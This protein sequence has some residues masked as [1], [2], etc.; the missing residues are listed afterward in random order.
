MAKKSNKI[1]NIA[2]DPGKHSTKYTYTGGDGKVVRGKFETSISMSNNLISSLGNTKEI[3]YDGNTYVVGEGSIGRTSKSN[4]K[5]DLIHKIC[6]L[7]A[8]S[9]CI[10]NGDTVNVVIGCPIAE[11]RSDEKRKA[12]RDY[13]F[14]KGR[15]EMVI[16]NQEM[17][18][19]TGKRYVMAE[20]TGLTIT[21]PERF[22]DKIVGVIDI[23]GLN[24]NGSLY[25]SGVIVEDSYFTAKLGSNVIA[26]KLR[27]DINNELDLSIDSN[28]MK[29]FMQQGYVTNFEEE[30]REMFT[31]RYKSHIEKI[32]EECDGNGWELKV[33][34]LIFIGGTSLM[35]KD[36]I[37]DLFPKAYIPEDSDYTNVNGFYK[38]INTI[39]KMPKGRLQAQ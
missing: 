8:V 23:G 36:Y 17:Y 37:L 31:K 13:M 24:C 27:K 4:S 2:I 3:T 33:M 11:F 7:V 10:N 28:M 22:K 16:G 19:Y 30:T 6:A 39:T 34:D 35:L 25:K 21:E 9:E 20:S 1:I 26:D 14:P 18:F 5:N 15:T 12:Y 29:Q 38:Y 32:K